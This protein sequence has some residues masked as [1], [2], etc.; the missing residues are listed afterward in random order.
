MTT[1]TAPMRAAIYVRVST[2]G[3]EQDGTSLVTQEQ[4][5][6]AWVTE[7]GGIVPDE[8]VYVEVHSGAYLWE[9]PQLTRLRAAMRAAAFD[10]L[11]VYAIDRLSREQ[12]HLGL[13]VS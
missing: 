9:R 3:Q 6:R 13:I 2:S 7:R 4:Y 12:D 10:V 1:T 5:C 11:V 8:Q